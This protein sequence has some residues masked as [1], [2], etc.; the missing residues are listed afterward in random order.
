MSRKKIVQD[1]LDFLSLTQ[2]LLT[3]I[4]SLAGLT[5]ALGV[6]QDTEA[7]CNSGAT[8]LP[9]LVFSFLSTFYLKTEIPQPAMKFG[10]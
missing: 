10:S 9:M 1:K 5:K 7:P 3:L 2:Y 8:A 6:T 4:Q